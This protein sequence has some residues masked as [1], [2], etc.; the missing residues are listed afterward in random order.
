M[1]TQNHEIMNETL[2]KMQIFVK[3]FFT[4]RTF[5]LSLKNLKFMDLQLNF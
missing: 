1:D 4:Y 3:L 2:V 5:N